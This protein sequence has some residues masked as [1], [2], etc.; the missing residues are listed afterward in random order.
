M[1]AVLLAARGG[2]TSKARALMMVTGWSAARRVAREPGAKRCELGKPLT[3][4]SVPAA[5][6]CERDMCRYGQD[7][8]AEVW[9][10]RRTRRSW[11]REPSEHLYGLSTNGYRWH[12]TTEQ[13]VFSMPEDREHSIFFNVRRLCGFHVILRSEYRDG[14][15]CIVDLQPRITVGI[16]GPEPGPDGPDGPRLTNI[17]PDFLK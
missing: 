15:F 16:A 17:R 14:F 7:A 11:R 3:V 2:C 12:E 9:A 8:S 5:R 6:L 4:P 13:Y 1:P 10:F